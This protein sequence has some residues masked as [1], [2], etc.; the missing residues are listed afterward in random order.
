MDYRAFYDMIMEEIEYLK[1]FDVA[2]EYRLCKALA[3]LYELQDYTANKIAEAVASGKLP[4][5][6]DD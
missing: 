6:P 4:V 5:D 2:D 1:A 3:A